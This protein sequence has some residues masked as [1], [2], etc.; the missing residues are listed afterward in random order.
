[1][2]EI[3]PPCIYVVGVLLISPLVL[4]LW[5][6]AG[7]GLTAACRELW[8]GRRVSVQAGGGGC[9]AGGSVNRTA[10]VSIRGSLLRLFLCECVQVVDTAGPVGDG[11]Y[12][13]ART[14][15]LAGCC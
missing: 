15:R 10:G 5:C 9:K 7:N 12:Q 6:R 8:E 2:A 13:R 3:G 14:N 4:Q 11:N 1:M